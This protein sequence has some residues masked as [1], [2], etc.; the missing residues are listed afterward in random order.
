M[1]DSLVYI[2]L[3]WKIQA[4]YIFS[5]KPWFRIKK[6][7][8]TLVISHYNTQ[9]LLLSFFCC[10]KYA[11]HSENLHLHFCRNFRVPTPFLLQ[12]ELH[13]KTRRDSFA[14]LRTTVNCSGLR[15]NFMRNSIETFRMLKR[16]FQRWWKEKDVRVVGSNYGDLTLSPRY[17]FTKLQRPQGKSPILLLDNLK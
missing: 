8:T 4:I 13:S 1:T 11:S 6:L 12:I 15:E 14:K 10:K 9:Y 2:A 3:G 16:E 5:L 17:H 7:N